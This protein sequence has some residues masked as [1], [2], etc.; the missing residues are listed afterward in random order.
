MLLP[1]PK[2]HSN[3]KIKSPA[4][5][6]YEFEELKATTNGAVPEVGVA[7]ITATGAAFG[8]TVIEHVAVLLPST[9]VT[10]IVAVPAAIAVIF[11]E[12]LTV[13]IDVLLDNQFTV[14]LVAFAGKTVAVK[15]D[16]FPALMDNVVGETATLVT[17]IVPEVTVIAEVAVLVPS[18]VVTVIFAEPA[19]LPVTKPV[20]LTVATVVFELDHVTL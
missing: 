11:P 9:V 15:V 6:S 18:T 5:G 13:T 12:L 19:T 10:V 17:A 4:S 20:V 14:L 3:P 16:V 1:S 8:V 2:S 7:V